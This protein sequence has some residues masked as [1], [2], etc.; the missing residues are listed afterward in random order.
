MTQ[1]IDMPPAIAADDPDFGPDGAWRAPVPCWYGPPRADDRGF[2]AAF[3]ASLAALPPLQSRA[4]RLRE[5]HGLEVIA[6]CAEMR[7]TPRELFD[8][9][10]CARLHLRRALERDWFPGAS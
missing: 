4:F 2:E 1:A 7:I 10:H 3:Q 9:L 6:V 5:V 8:L